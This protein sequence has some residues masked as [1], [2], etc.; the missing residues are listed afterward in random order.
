VPVS[1]VYLIDFP[2]IIKKFIFGNVL[3][4]YFPDIDQS[5]GKTMNCGKCNASNDADAVFCE[6]CG[7]TL[8]P[9]PAKGRRP[10]FYALLLVPVLLLAAGFGYYKF[11][12]P[13]G[14]AAEVNGETITVT[15]LEAA[16]RTNGNPAG[17]SAEQQGQLRYA[18]LS[19]LITERIALQEAK[20]AD[21]RVSTEEVQAAVANMRTA[22]GLD[23]QAFTARVEERYGSMD[24]FRK[25]LERRLAIRKFVDQNVTAGAASPADAN[26]RLN[27]WLRNCT[28]RA[29]VRV[30]LNEELPASGSGCGCCGKGPAQQGTGPGNAPGKPGCGQGKGCGP[31]AG[32]A[33]GS[34]EAK[35][36]VEAA[37]VAALDYWKKQ[38]GSGPVEAK[39]TDFGCHVQVDIVANSKI[40]KSLRYQNGTITEM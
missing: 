15:E 6:Q 19:E 12:L 2:K 17:L 27:Q 26:M 20:K 38:N 7:N 8:V 4:L 33:A 9:V 39:V 40:A 32:P 31:Q 28:A 30:S 10:Y 1:L 18:A 14:I 3:A 37:R 11:I 29:S 5:G 21:V 36:Q 13:S 24:A 16:V 34:P 35:A 23:E 22:S 25:G